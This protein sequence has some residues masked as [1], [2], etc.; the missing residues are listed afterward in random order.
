MSRKGPNKSVFSSGPS[1]AASMPGGKLTSPKLRPAVRTTTETCPAASAYAREPAGNDA[2]P[3]TLARFTRHSRSSSLVF[4]LL[5][6][7][8]FISL[9]VALKREQ[10]IREALNSAVMHQSH[11]FTAAILGVSTLFDDF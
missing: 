7:F 5:T 4:R 9:G 1:T 8:M 11:H 10:L 2:A 3:L 6:T